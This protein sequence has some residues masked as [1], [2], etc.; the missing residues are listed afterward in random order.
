LEDAQWKERDV[1][2]CRLLALQRKPSLCRLFQSAK[3]FL[4]AH[5]ASLFRG[6]AFCVARQ[7][8]LERDS[9]ETVNIVNHAVLRIRE[10]KIE[11]FDLIACASSASPTVAQMRPL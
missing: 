8:R 11:P 9:S 6:L 7:K 1:G 2:V 3:P 4:E 10:M 5:F